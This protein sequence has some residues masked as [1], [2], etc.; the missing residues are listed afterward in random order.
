MRKIIGLFIIIYTISQITSTAQTI[1]GVVIDQNTAQPVPYAT[2]IILQNSQG[3]TT[4]STGV[5]RITNLT[6][7]RCDIL[8]SNIGYE[9]TTIP[10]QLLSAAKNLN[11]TIELKPT[12]TNIETVIVRP[13]QRPDRAI[14]RMSG[15]AARSLI[16]DDAK[17]MAGSIGDPARLA[18]NFAGV[19]TGNL[20]ENGLV[21]RGN[22]PKGIMWRVEGVEVFNPNHIAGG[23]MAGGGFVNIFGSNLLG[24]SDFYTGAFPAEF[25]NATSAP[26]T[27]AR[28]IELGLRLE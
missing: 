19:T 12:P 3:T 5:F 1:T 14:N 6:V 10:E 23:N 7:G 28:Y 8:V 20:Q 13:R 11:L 24:N 15:V 2:V 9:P 25:G 18:A 27:I 16:I 26:A 17:M 22:S 21:I 4:D